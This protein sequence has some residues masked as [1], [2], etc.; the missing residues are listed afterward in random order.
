MPTLTLTLTL[1]LT[2]S[3]TVTL[4]LT[5]EMSAPSNRLCPFVDRCRARRLA[6]S[7]LMSAGGGA[8]EGSARGLSSVARTRR[9]PLTW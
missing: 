5:F 4:T 7:K 3:V 9:L 1:T 2:M 8:R 6:S